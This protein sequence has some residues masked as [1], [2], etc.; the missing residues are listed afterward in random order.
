VSRFIALLALSVLLFA[1]QNGA[2]PAAQTPS[3]SPQPKVTAAV[4]QAGEA[5]AGLAACPGSGP[6]AGYIS[7][8]QTSNPTLAGRITDEWQLLRSHGAV[9]AAVSLFVA[10]P[11]AC[12]VELGATA[13]FKAAAS[14][15]AVFADEGQAERAWGSGILGF[16]PPA[17][18]ILSPGLVR[19][20][21]T[22]R[23]ASSWTYTRPSVQLACWR[24]SVFVSLVVLTNLD[25]STFKTVTAAID[26]RLN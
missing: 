3:A 18:D 16:A 15:V 11:V 19:G 2:K 20:T 24:R 25:S 8:L 9:D 22:G 4:L 12:T 1:C 10:D 23:G 5:P 6:V 17:P 13:R 14:F 21:A 7:S 26:A